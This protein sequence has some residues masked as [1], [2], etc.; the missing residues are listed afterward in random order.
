MGTQLRF[1]M[2]VSVREPL[3]V[4]AHAHICAYFASECT[5]EYLWECMCA[6]IFMSVHV[7]GRV[8]A[9]ACVFCERR[10][11]YVFSVCVCVRA[12]AFTC[13]SVSVFSVHACACMCGWSIDQLNQCQNECVV[14]SQVSKWIGDRQEN[15]GILVVTTLPSG[16]WLE[17]AAEHQR[18]DRNAYLV[19]FSDDARTELTGNTSIH[20]GRGI[21]NTRKQKKSLS[22]PPSLLFSWPTKS[23]V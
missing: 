3:C 4:C 5:C 11:A 7:R 9:C 21:R 23:I 6:R 13:K 22:G 14:S 18:T 16:A 12:H 1:C 15:N 8:H 2:G 17:A 20:H 19:V 10:C